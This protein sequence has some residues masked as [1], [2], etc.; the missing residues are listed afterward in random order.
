MSALE[1]VGELWEQV[2]GGQWGGRARDPVHFQMK[3]FRPGRPQTLA[4]GFRTVFPVT[5]LS[6]ED[7]AWWIS[8]GGT[9]VGAGG[10][11]SDLGSPSKGIL[12]WLK[13]L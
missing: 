6:Q 13:K 10:V 12:N 8:K 5:S 4:S 1:R 3:Q 9:Y 2:F 7:L 11:V